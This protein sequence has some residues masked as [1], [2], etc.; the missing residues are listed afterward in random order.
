MDAKTWL[1][2]VTGGASVNAAAAAAGVPQKTLDTQLR[3]KTGL[4]PEM[5]VR[6]ARAYGQSPIAALVEN[7]LLTELEARN[8]AGIRAGIESANIARL[9]RKATDEQLLDE[10]GQRLEERTNGSPFGERNYPALM[11]DASRPGE[12]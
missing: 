1:N 8:A 2:R 5:I 6:I 12:D 11:P 7:G 4:K 9:L 3:S 10:I